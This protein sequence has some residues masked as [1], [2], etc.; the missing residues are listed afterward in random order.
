[1][2]QAYLLAFACAGWL[3]ETKIDTKLL[4]HKKNIN[5]S[6]IEYQIVICVITSERSK[7]SSY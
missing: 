5:Q 2:M 1:M 6:I 3:I 4:H 7:R